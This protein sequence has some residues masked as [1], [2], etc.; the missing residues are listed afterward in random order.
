MTELIVEFLKEINIGQLIA[1]AGMFW[2]FYSRLDNKMNEKFGKI[3]SKID[4]M[5]LKMAEMDKRLYGIETVLHMK[6]CCVLKQDQ[7]LKRVE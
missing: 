3:D 1:V 2:F 4:D 5:N 6:D 7:N